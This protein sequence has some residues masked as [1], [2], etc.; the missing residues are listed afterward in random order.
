MQCVFPLCPR[1]VSCGHCESAADAGGSGSDEGSLD[2]YL[3][4]IS[5]YPL[6]TQS[7]EV[8]L[9]QRIQPG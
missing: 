2:V 3:R 1:C 5:R 7:D 9:A 4:D 6:I 8:A